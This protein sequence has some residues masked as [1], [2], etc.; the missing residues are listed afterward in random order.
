MLGILIAIL[1]GAV[2]AVAFYFG[3]QPYYEDYEAYD[4]YED[5]YEETDEAEEVDS[6]A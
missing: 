4:E 6:K 1:G 2:A 5:E 3:R